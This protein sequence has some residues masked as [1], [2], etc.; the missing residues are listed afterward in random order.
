LLPAF[1]TQDLNIANA[2]AVTADPI[3]L[4]FPPEIER[5]FLDRYFEDSLPHMHRVL[6]VAL[7]LV[8]IFGLLDWAL[9]PAEAPRIWIIRF[10]ILCPLITAL[11][12]FSHSRWFKQYMQLSVAAMG[13]ITG[14][15]IVA[16]ITLLP[17]P[18][19]YFF[20]AGVL[21][22]VMVICTFVRL[23]F[24]YAVAAAAII[25]IGYEVAII[26]SHYP[27]SII[28]NNT[29]FLL[30]TDVVAGI[31]GYS[32]ERYTRQDFIQSRLLKLR[33]EELKQQQ[34]LAESLL[35]QT[36]PSVVAAELK[37][38]GF[39]APRYY[40]DVT[41]LFTDFKGFTLET[42]RLA[43]EELVNALNDYF[44]AFDQI[45]SRYG[46]EK[47]KTIGDSYMCVSG[48][49][50]HVA[51]HAV[52]AML[53]AYEILAQVKN[54]KMP[55]KPGWSIRIGLHTGPVISGIVGIRKLAFDVW[56]ESVNFAS[57]MESSG[58]PD[59]I[60]LSA[61]TFSRVKDFF[62]CEHRGRIATKEKR[63]YDMYFAKGVQPSLMHDAL[64]G[65]IPGA[66]QRRYYT[67]FHHDLECFPEILANSAEAVRATS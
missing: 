27:T 32:I 49:P 58:C 66:F 38:K 67:Y 3:T 29:F 24:V 54:R 1:V 7:G 60:N 8:A 51:S 31:V 11:C 20:Y 14:L 2:L 17:A 65:Q 55:G 19:R 52:D 62:V 25:S 41:I 40:E 50:T 63:E 22:V 6:P 53:A 35:L 34:E 21:L 12:V 37:E 39:V 9:A 44:T 26:A 47:L 64:P 48:L 43:A 13:V 28:L 56:G 18:A 57:R 61:S 15:G 45:T 16:I 42:E 23:L 30:G 4:R 10:G 36:L 46:L 5:E 33:T 59:E